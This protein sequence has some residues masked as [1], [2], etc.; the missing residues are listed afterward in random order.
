MALRQPVNPAICRL[1]PL[2]FCCLQCVIAPRVTLGDGCLPV[3]L[4]LDRG[5]YPRLHRFKVETCA[6]LHRWKLDRSLGKFAHH[7]LHER[8][9][10]EFI[11]EPIVE[12]KRALFTV[13]Q[14]GPLKWVQSQIDDDRPIYLLR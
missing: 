5:L 11:S 10:P 6:A 14:T 9:T 8:E 3:T 4:T 2:C 13:R 1:L 12:G 7:V